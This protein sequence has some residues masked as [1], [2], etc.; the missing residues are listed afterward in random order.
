MPSSMCVDL[1]VEFFSQNDQIGF[2]R[3]SARIYRAFQQTKLSP[4]IFTRG[5]VNFFCIP[6]TPSFYTE[7]QKRT[8]PSTEL[9]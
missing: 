7:L 6:L 5:A 9:N 1:L 2:F 3:S 8:E 4:H